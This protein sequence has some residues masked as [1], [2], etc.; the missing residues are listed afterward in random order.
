[1]TRWFT[2]CLPYIPTECCRSL[3]PRTTNRHRLKKL[4][5]KAATL[6]KGLG[7]GWPNSRKT[8]CQNLPYSS[9]KATEKLLFPPPLCIFSGTE[10]EADVPPAPIPFARKHRCSDSPARVVSDGSSHELSICSHLAAMRLMVIEGAAIHT[11]C[12]H[13]S[14]SWYQ[15]DPEKRV[16]PPGINEAE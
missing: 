2:Y 9:K 4:Q 16:S 12:P 7:K 15:W 11:Q 14:S 1:M 8:F 10:Q 3:Q 13:P 5:E 6:A